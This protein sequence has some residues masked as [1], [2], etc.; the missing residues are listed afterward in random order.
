MKQK[1]KAKRVCGNCGTHVVYVYP[2][3]VFCSTRFC[4]NKNPI[5]ETLWCCEEWNPNS[6]ECYCVEEATKKQSKK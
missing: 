3:K 4:E 1:T 6:Q 2:D 5:V